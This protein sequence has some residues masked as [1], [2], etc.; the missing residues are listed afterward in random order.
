M[1]KSREFNKRNNISPRN[2]KFTNIVIAAI[3]WG[4]LLFIDALTI[5][6]MSAFYKS[7]R[8]KDIKILLML[9]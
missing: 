6:F 5:A 3:S 7:P 1:N 9:F 4:F 8:F 2:I